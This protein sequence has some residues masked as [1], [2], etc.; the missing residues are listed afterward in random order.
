MVNISH[1]TELCLTEKQKNRLILSVLSALLLFC[2]CTN[3]VKKKNTLEADGL[4]GNV[5]SV[6]TKGYSAVTDTFGHITKGEIISDEWGFNNTFLTYDK[7]G[8]WTKYSSYEPNDSIIREEIPEYN[9]QGYAIGQQIYNRGI[10]SHKKVFTNDVNGN[11]IEYRR[12][13]PSDS[14]VSKSV[15]KYDNKGN[16]IGAYS[17][18]STDNLTNKILHKYD[19]RG[20]CVEILSY[21]AENKLNNKTVKKYDAKGQCAEK[22]DYDADENVTAKTIYKYNEK[23]FWSEIFVYGTDNTLE[24]NNTYIYQYD[25]NDNWIEQI[26]YNKNGATKIIERYIEYYK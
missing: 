8:N 3:E 16:E 18:T 24:S 26:I 6:H 12:Y 20:N 11:I 7:N 15:Y 23:G 19:R 5:K 25:S 17:Y 2:A 1:Y 13:S 21:N 14:L 10:L 22:I 9:N 4:R